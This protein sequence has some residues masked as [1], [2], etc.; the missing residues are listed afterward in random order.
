MGAA[1]ATTSKLR[2]IHSD[3]RIIALLLTKICILEAAERNR[4]PGDCKD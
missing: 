1:T 3:F 2:I 4:S